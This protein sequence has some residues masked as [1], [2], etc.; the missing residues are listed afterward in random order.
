MQ[1]RPIYKLFFAFVLVFSVY[2]LTYA[3]PF[4]ELREKK[5]VIAFYNVENLFDTIDDPIKDDDEFLPTS[6]KN[7]NHS[8]YTDKLDKIAEVVSGIDST[9]F[10]VLIGLCEVENIQVL[11]DLVKNPELKSGKYF[12]VLIEGQDQRGIDVAL[13]VSKKKFKVIS[14]NSYTI[15]LG[16]DNRPTR[17]ILHV[18][19]KI[20]GGPTLN[21]FINH[22]PSRYGGAEKSEPKR[23]AA[24]QV[25]KSKT[26]SIANLYPN[27]GIIC[28]GDFNDYP[29]NKSLS[30]VLISDGSVLTNLM[31]GLK[32][33]KRGSYN[34]RGNWGFLDQ[35]IVSNNLV[36]VNLPMIVKS[37]TAPFFTDSML[38]VHPEYG[39][40]KP[41][42][43]YGGPNYYGGY[44]DHLPVYTILAY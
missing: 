39:D 43:T 28:M 9:S 40:L 13:L 23:I 7:W 26:D 33:S 15:D 36:D 5:A 20:K 1:N 34:Y 3:R 35:I 10:P 24:A 11:E 22:W 12:P 41:S 4:T 29:E 21:V 42:R 14:S 2:A 16:E 38:Y 19:G 31:D 27:E 6:E 37:S 8:R 25:L 17:D 32:D 30:E 18:R 44:S